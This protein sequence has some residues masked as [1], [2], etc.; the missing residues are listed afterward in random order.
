M[1]PGNV[2]GNQS[3]VT[4]HLLETSS[5]VNSK[6]LNIKQVIYLQQSLT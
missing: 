4:K 6:P 2:T 3:D 5:H 1:N